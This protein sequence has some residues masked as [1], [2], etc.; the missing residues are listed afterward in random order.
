[1]PVT[2]MA[3]LGD[4]TLLSLVAKDEVEAV[5]ALLTTGQDAC[6]LS[7]EGSRPAHEIRS[8]A[9]L[10]LLVEHGAKLD[11]AE[12]FDRIKRLPLP[13]AIAH[14]AST[15]LVRAFVHAGAHVEPKQCQASPLTVAATVG[16]IDILELLASLGARVLRAGDTTLHRA[17]GRNQ[18]EV[19]TWLLQNGAPP[20]APDRTYQ[21]ESRPLHEAASRGA[22]DAIVV[23]LEH[24]ADPR[25]RETGG[26]DTDGF[27]PLH[28]AAM[29]EHE[30]AFRLLWHAAPD[31]ADSPVGSEQSEY[32]EDMVDGTP[33]SAVLRELKAQTRAQG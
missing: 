14:G 22:A 30:A 4:E 27:A 32:L 6:G 8:V 10:E 12:A 28:S 21:S 26:G 3:P 20:N 11:G 29:M 1:M 17:A 33:L 5:R 19:V 25:A 2:K 16:R 7:A 24:G 13:M 18:V 15:E 9:M 31:V 23:L